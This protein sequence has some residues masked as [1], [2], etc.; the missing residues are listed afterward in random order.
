MIYKS[1][2]NRLPEYFRKGNNEKLYKVLYGEIDELYDTIIDI[3]S[4]RDIDKAFGKTLDLLGENIGQERDGEDDEA[5]RMLLKIKIIAN[6]S[7]GDIPTMN[8]VFRAIL[9]DSYK[10]I[11]ETWDK[12]EYKNEPAA[13][14][15]KVNTGA[16]RRYIKILSSVKAG[17]VK[18]YYESYL[19]PENISLSFTDVKIPLDLPWTG[20]VETQKR[21][22]ARFDEH[23]A[24]AKSDFGYCQRIPF[25]GIATTNIVDSYIDKPEPML[26][27]WNIRLKQKREQLGI[28]ECGGV[29][30]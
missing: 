10:G 7:K 23:M 19:K 2:F 6:F 16:S 29:S 21:E 26:N 24:L 13:I 30:I 28:I 20:I 18:V 9:G 25:T 5:Y 3:R 14:V 1:A 11:V 15:I 17:G 12:E 8:R 27:I 4:T 22:G